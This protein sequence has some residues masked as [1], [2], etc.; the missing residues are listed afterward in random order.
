MFPTNWYMHI[1]L[2][3]ASC[4]I[5]IA[6]SLFLR[7]LFRFLGVTCISLLFKN[8]PLNTSYKTEIIFARDFAL[9]NGSRDF[10]HYFCA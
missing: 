2:L 10:A 9:L 7:N 1:P 3:I 6:I 8:E 4:V 5:L